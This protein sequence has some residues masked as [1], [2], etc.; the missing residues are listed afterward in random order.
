MSVIESNTHRIYAS[1]QSNFVN[2]TFDLKKEA[3][4]QLWDLKQKAMVLSHLFVCFLFFYVNK[5]NFKS[6][7]LCKFY[8]NVGNVS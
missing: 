8:E 3:L 5:C 6:F 4:H 7:Y 1:I 2:V